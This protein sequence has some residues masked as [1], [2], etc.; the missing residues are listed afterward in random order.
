M[1]NVYKDQFKQRNHLVEFFNY[2]LMFVNKKTM[3]LIAFYFKGLQ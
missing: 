1:Y 3:L 2:S